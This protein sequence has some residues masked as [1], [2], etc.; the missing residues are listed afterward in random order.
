MMTFRGLTLQRG[1]L[2]LLENTS[3]SLHA[4]WKVALTGANGAGKSSLFKLLLGELTPDA[5]ELQMSGYDRI[6]HLAQEVPG[7][8]QPALD[9]VLEGHGELKA[10]EQALLQAEAEGNNQRLAE[11][12]GQYDLLQ[13]YSKRA[14]AEQLLAGLGFAQD[15]FNNPVNSFSGGWRIRLNLARTLF[16]PSDLL[17]LDEPTNHLDLD[18]TLWLEGWLR[19]YPG[20]LL[21]IS[22]DRDFIDNV[23]DHLL[24][25]EHRQLWLY[26]GGYSAFERQRAERLAQQQSMYEKQQREI[27]HMEDFVRRFK[28]KASKAKQAQSRIKALER[29]EKIAPAHVDSPFHFDFPEAD[30]SSDP[31]LVMRDAELGYQQAAVVRQVG[32]T[33]HPGQ[34]IGLLGPNGAGKSTLIK[35]LVGDVPLVSGQ[36]TAGEHLYIGYFAQHQLEAL[37]VQAT[38]LLHLQRLSP[39]AREQ[40]LRN[41]LGGFGF[42]GDEVLAPVGRFSG[43]EKARLALAMIAWQ[44]PNLLL[45]DEPTNHLDLEMRH[46][47]TLAL[48]DFEGAVLVVSHDRHLLSN[49]VDEYWLVADGRVTD[50]DGD[51]EDYAR[52]LKERQAGQR[53]AEKQPQAAVATSSAA[54]VASGNKK[55]DRKEAARLRELLKPLKKQ[56]EKLEQQM[57]TTR[58]QL[59]QTEASLGDT[60]LYSD[61]ARKP[62]LQQLLKD[63]GNLQQQ[64]ET[65]EMEWLEAG[66][67]LEQK[68]AELGL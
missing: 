23:V 3:V 12:H 16:M 32:F 39:D 47:L 44:K 66:E 19:S 68:T 63:Q 48:Q 13:G 55:L 33:L 27:A 61:A 35:S 42:Q 60:S 40:E 14:E 8:T 49:T 20:T 67:A 51:L 9:Y 59:E 21:L 25:V 62:E 36:R 7:L 28:A 56:L 54:A 45:L 43:G 46:A 57:D 17:L 22:H 58:L 4:G 50:F 24:H 41:F 38:P 6:A 26:R 5:G 34:R 53:R 15:S 30:Q 65:L 11:L 18:A 31:L 1:D 64:L 10:V 37:D 52:W 29:M 2:R